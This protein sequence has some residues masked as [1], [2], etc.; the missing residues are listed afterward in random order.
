[1]AITLSKGSQITFNSS[2]VLGQLLSWDYSESDT[3]VD[4]SN[5]SSTRREYSN[6]GN[7]GGEFNIEAQFDLSDDGQDSIRA[8]LGGTQATMVIYP[9]GWAA[10]S[11]RPKLIFSAIVSSVS[12][13][14]AGIEDVISVS[15]SGKVLSF[16]EDII[17]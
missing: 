10:A 3:Q 13:S 1:M 15:F 8:K 6:L 17:T 11:G 9:E 5:L 7:I 4:I 2:E 12:V 16:T 14:A